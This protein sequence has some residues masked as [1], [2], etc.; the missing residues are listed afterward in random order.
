V[1][2]VPDPVLLRK[3]GSAGNRTRDPW[4]CSLELFF[5]VIALHVQNLSPVC[6]ISWFVTFFFLEHASA[7]RTFQFC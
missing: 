5:F 1:Y 7:D 4:F 3:S 2:P 6:L